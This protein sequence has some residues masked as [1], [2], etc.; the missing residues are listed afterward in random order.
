MP[1]KRYYKKPA[2]QLEIAKKR[3]SLLFSMAKDSFKKD[4][5]IS[6]KHIAMARR[7]AMKYKIKFTS[8]QKRTV[9]KNCYKYLVPS[10][11]CRVRL[12]KSRLI[13]YCSGCKHYTRFP[14]K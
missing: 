11:N 5:S 6:N 14:V 10:V 9:C 3:I 4:S 13:Y 1:K 2:K 12:H 8:N 7:I